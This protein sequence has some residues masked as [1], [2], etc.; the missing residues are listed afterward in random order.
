MVCRNFR[1]FAYFRRD[2]KCS[3]F[4]WLLASWLFAA[5]PLNPILG[6][7]IAFDSVDGGADGGPIPCA[8]WRVR[9]WGLAREDVDWSVS[10][11]R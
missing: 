7:E 4:V 2:C 10:V 11:E 6:Q 9:R 3:S 1:R 8:D 5:D